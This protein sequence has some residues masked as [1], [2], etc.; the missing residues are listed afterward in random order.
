MPHDT[1]IAEPGVILIEDNDFIVED[2]KDSMEEENE[3]HFNIT[4]LKI[5]NFWEVFYRIL[6]K[7][8][9]G[10]LIDINL[11]LFKFKEIFIENVGI[12]NG[13]DIAQYLF[14]FNSR[15][16][17]AVYS[18]YFE[19]YEGDLRK[20]DS[21]ILIIKKEGENTAAFK[22]ALEPF[23]AKVDSN[24]KL[25]FINALPN[26]QEFVQYTDLQKEN[27]LKT[28]VGKIQAKQYFKA[29]GNYAWYVTADEVVL[30]HHGPVIEYNGMEKYE[31][32]NEIQ[33]ELKNQYNIQ[34]KPFLTDNDLK[35]IAYEKD[36]IPLIFWNFSTPEILQANLTSESTK[37]TLKHLPLEWKKNFN[38]QAAQAIAEFFYYRNISTEKA[39]ELL[40][41]LINFGRY[42]FSKILLKLAKDK[43]D[44]ADRI[45]DYFA[46]FTD[47][48]ENKVLDIFVGNVNRIEPDQQTA[49]VTLKN[50]FDPKISTKEPFSLDLLKEHGVFGKGTQF[51][52]ILFKNSLGRNSYDI[53]PL[54]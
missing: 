43:V 7:M 37:E 20:L 41:L 49:W 16:P 44:S 40:L 39:K 30:D 21:K 47:I 29:I 26:L 34:T 10:A 22:K 18:S 27:F 32:L 46:P 50:L 8:P 9:Y 4:E 15:L 13:I 42:E 5:S 2:I 28:A 14:E 45:K 52:Y 19:D 51:Q 6:L 48:V 36:R 33:F 3:D 11:Q 23:F 24:K 12:S 53:E 31:A 25:K 54:Y 1:V 38:F 17:I 35:K